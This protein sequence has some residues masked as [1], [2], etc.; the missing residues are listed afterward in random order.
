[1]HYLYRERVK[2][3]RHINENLIPH[4]SWVEEW[5]KIELDDFD[6]W[7][8]NVWDEEDM[9]NF[10]IKKIMFGQSFEPTTFFVTLQKCTL[11]MS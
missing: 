5:D 11:S 10:M 3:Y 2:K 8:W 6:Q 7:Q 4:K 9:T 1:M